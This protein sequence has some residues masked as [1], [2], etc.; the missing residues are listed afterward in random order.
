MV[1]IL[2]TSTKLEQKVTDFSQFYENFEF[3][4]NTRRNLPK[5]FLLAY[6]LLMLNRSLLIQ[7]T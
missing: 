6:I 1:N 3:S 2:V 7:N 5:L 4:D